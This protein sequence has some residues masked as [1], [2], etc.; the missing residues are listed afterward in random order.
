[1]KRLNE[2]FFGEEAISFHDA[3]YYYGTY[4]GTALIAVCVICSIY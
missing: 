1:M 4:V 2:Y 3:A